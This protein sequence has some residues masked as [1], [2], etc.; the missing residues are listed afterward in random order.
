MSRYHIFTQQLIVLNVALALGLVLELEE[1]CQPYLNVESE[2]HVPNCESLPKFIQWFFRLAFSI[3]FSILRLVDEE[4]YNRISELMVVSKMHKNASKFMRFSGNLEN[5]LVSMQMSKCGCTQF[6]INRAG[7]ARI[8]IICNLNL[9]L[10]TYNIAENGQRNHPI[11]IVSTSNGKRV[12]AK[13][14]LKYHPNILWILNS[15]RFIEKFILLISYV[16]LDPTYIQEISTA[17]V[18][19]AI[20]RKNILKLFV[21]H[22]IENLKKFSIKILNN[23]NF[24]NWNVIIFPENIFS[25]LKSEGYI[26]PAPANKFLADPFLMRWGDSDYCFVEEFDFG[27]RKGNIAVY[28]LFEN[29]AFRLGTA[30]EV[31]THL[32]YPFIFSKSGEIYML[33]ESLANGSLKAYRML[34]SPTEWVEDHEIFSEKNI[35]DPNI[36]E[37]L[38][39]FYLSITID[40][41]VTGDNC[42]EQYLFKSAN[43]NEGPWMQV[44]KTPWITDSKRARNGG[45]IDI[46]ENE[47]ESI[48][49]K[50]SQDN[51]NYTYGAAI[52]IDKIVARDQKILLQPY[53]EISPRAQLRNIHHLSTNYKFTALDF[54]PESRSFNKSS[55][56]NFFDLFIL[57]EVG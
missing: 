29:S 6:E 10:L 34:D 52:L 48:Q 14:F 9:A 27:T 13:S 31:A 11:Y 56:Y 40:K 7:E 53:I 5:C 45:V 41:G 37:L 54:I 8:E 55:Y 36:F 51:S 30:L 26:L 1:E 22:F 44:S 16:S 2:F 32:S 20:K 49:Y 50:V 57:R 38:G 39:N 25:E 23:G 46:Q 18:P 42:S 24:P 19:I 15:I 43:S 35:S 47:K 28:E 17:D 33:P 3:E 12:I 21:F 4:S